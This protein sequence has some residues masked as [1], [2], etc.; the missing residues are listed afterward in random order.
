MTKFKILALLAG[1]VLLLA[2]RRRGFCAG[3]AQARPVRW[4]G[5]RGRRDSPPTALSSPPLLAPTRSLR[6][7]LQA[8]DICLK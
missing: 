1:V 2:T 7:W 5:H 4:N 3:G 8:V 6:R